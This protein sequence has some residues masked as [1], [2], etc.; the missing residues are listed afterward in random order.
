M[1]AYDVVV[2]DYDGTLF[3]T[4]PAI[5]HCLQRAFAALQRPI[6]ALEDVRSTVKTGLS[7]PDSLSMLDPSLRRHPVTLNELV[8]AYRALYLEEAAPLL[9]PFSG[10]TDALH[11]LNAGGVICAIVSNKGAAAIRRSLEESRLIP[12]VDLILADEPGLPRKPDPALLTHHILPKFARIRK[13]QILM[14]GDT[15]TDIIFANASGISCCW[16]SYGYGDIERCRALAPKHEIA[17]IAELPPL[18]GSARLK[19]D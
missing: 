14:V 10:V 18:V 16:A 2:F 17:S 15:E 6:P 3:D 1:T 12:F 5:V 11:R 13:R 4:R 8:G 9:K 19:W 7:L